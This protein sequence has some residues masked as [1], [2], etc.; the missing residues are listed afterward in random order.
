MITE[1][2]PESG[3]VARQ[4]GP[5]RE[6]VLIWIVWHFTHANLWDHHR[7]PSAGRFSSH[8]TTEVA[9]NPVK[10]FAPPQSRHPRQRYPASMAS[11]H[12]PFCI[13]A[14]AHAPSYAKGHS[15]YSGAG[16]LVLLGV[17]QHRR[18]LV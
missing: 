16:P 11:D 18:L 1:Y 8:P 3:F 2:K 6:S 17:A 5:D 4:G 9:Y 10:E 14:V 15:G 12:V 13:G 7:W